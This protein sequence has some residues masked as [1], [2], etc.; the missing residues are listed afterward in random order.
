M[1]MTLQFPSA[2]LRAFQALMAI[3]LLAACDQTAGGGGP[4]RTINASEPV[5]VALLVP[6]DSGQGELTFIGSSLVNAARMARRDLQGADIQLD[7]YPTRGDA[8][9][10]AAVA[11]RAISEGAQVIVGPFFST[12]TAAVAPV[13]AG[14]G[15]Q[16]LSFSN[17]AEIAGS[18]V[19]IL[20]PT[21]ENIANRVVRFATSQ[22]KRDVA[23][24][25]S[26]DVAGA[27]GRDAAV[28]A[29]RNAGGTVAGTYGYELSPQ[30]I[31]TAA[32]DI[33]AQVQAA[34][35]TAVLLTDDPASGL[36]FLAPVLASS[37]LRSGETQ[38]LGLTR[39]NV[40][41]QAAATPSLQGGVF[42]IPDPNL[43]AQFEQ[44]YVSTYGTQ[45][46]A[47]AG[48]AYDAVAAIGAMVRSAQA[49]S[50]RA[51]SRGQITDRSGFVGVNGVFRFRGDG[52]NERG[53]ALFQ[54]K[55]GQAVMID[56]APRSF[57]GGF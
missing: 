6:L 29:I 12:T 30:G 56:P 24:I 21:F 1:P 44:R 19:F 18:N 4:A 15:L 3:L 48:L 45:P 28:T 27:A 17:N 7:I 42:A 47:T 25:H 14:S 9:T 41:A 36:T 54:L 2:L 35:A 33:A 52:Q 49:G 37:G 40:P 8:N 38:F 55:D 11:Q 39:W 32:P 57:G 53:L 43:T 26:T 16:V 23:V 20:G 10:A 22:G 50:G 13:A 5:K 46:H 51:L 34:G 31:S